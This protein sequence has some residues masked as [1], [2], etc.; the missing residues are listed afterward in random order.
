MSIAGIIAGLAVIAFGLILLFFMLRMVMEKLKSKDWPSVQGKILN[1]SLTKQHDEDS[2]KYYLIHLKYDYELSGNIYH[3]YSKITR[4]NKKKRELKKEFAV[5]SPITAYYNPMNPQESV[6][7]PGI[8][9]ARI[10]V[11]LIIPIIIII[12]G[13]SVMRY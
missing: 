4:Y 12:V 11:M 6:L 8:E 13:A 3:G 7:E 9:L 10:A 2:G 1:M 5:D